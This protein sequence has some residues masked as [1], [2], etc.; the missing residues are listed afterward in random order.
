MFVDPRLPDFDGCDLARR[1]RQ[2]GGL[3]G[4]RF[5]AI[6]GHPGRGER[7]RVL[8]AGCDELFLKPL[9]PHVLDNLLAH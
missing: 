3:R 4:A 2:G 9:D 5:Y 7:E 8:K 6:A 1:M